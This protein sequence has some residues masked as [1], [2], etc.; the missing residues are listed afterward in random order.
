MIHPNCALADAYS[1]AIMVLGEKDGLA[2]AEKLKLPVLL[3]IHGE[4]G[5]I[6]ERQT[7]EFGAYLLEE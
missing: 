7:P 1:T 2:F 5:E 3:L 6:I 4:Q